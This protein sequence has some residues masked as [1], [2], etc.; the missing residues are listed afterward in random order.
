MIL[1]QDQQ[2]VSAKGQIVSQL[3]DS[4]IVVRK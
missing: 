2:T 3:P 1:E 4:D